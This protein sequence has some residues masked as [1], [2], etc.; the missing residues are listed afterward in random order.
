MSLSILTHQVHHS[1]ERL[2]K[3]NNFLCKVCH[4][5]RTFLIHI[6]PRVKYFFVLQVVVLMSLAWSLVLCAPH[7][8]HYDYHDNHVKDVSKVNPYVSKWHDW[9]KNLEYTLGVFW[10]K[11][12]VTTGLNISVIL[13]ATIDLTNQMSWTLTQSLSGCS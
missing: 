8:G 5:W 9:K 1:V 12:W 7:D 3:V 2:S 10:L 11:S 6:T 4:F 13:L